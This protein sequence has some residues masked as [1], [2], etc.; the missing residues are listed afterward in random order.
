MQY[1]HGDI[2]SKTIVKQSPRCPYE[3]CSGGSTYKYVK[4]DLKKAYLL[5]KKASL[6]DDRA[7]YEALKILL[8]QIDYKSINYDSYLLK[9]L[10]INYGLSKD[11]YNKDVL[12]FAKKLLRSQQANHR[13]LGGFIIYDAKKNN[14][15]NIQNSSAFSINAKKIGLQSCEKTGFKYMVLSQ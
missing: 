15:F 7:S 13:C 5:F 11:D 8:K 14:Y 6:E 1:Y 12:M 9:K 3:R 10:K 4:K 2:G